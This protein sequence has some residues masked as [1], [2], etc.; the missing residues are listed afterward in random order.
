MV[1]LSKELVRRVMVL[2]SQDWREDLMV[3]GSEFQSVSFWPEQEA[4]AEVTNSLSLT[5]G[6]IVRLYYRYRYPLF[7]ILE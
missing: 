7:V 3:E 2:R 4:K 5:W 1:S 6:H